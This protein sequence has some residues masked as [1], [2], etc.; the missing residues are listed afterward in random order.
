MSDKHTYILTQDGK[1]MSAHTDELYHHGVKGQKWGVRRYQ[2]ADGTL[3]EAGKKRQK[4][5][6]EK[7]R[8]KEKYDDDWK[9]LKGERDV[10]DT[11]TGRDQILKML[12]YDSDPATK[13]M[14]TTYRIIAD[15]ELDYAK[16]SYVD[17][18]NRYVDKWGKETYMRDITNN[19]TFVNGRG[20]VLNILAED[21][22][23]LYKDFV[24]KF[25]K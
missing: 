11:K 5:Q 18:V 22:D 25:K 17:A 9:L 2:N 15:R 10:E 1:L 16:S 6:E 12:S 20:R 21:E 7:Q 14:L 23:D 3:T 4:K 24:E 8:K 19:K 13:Q